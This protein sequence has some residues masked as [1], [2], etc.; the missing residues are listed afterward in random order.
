MRRRTRVLVDGAAGA[1]TSADAI[2]GSSFP[3]VAGSGRGGIGLPS[4]AEPVGGGVSAKNRRD[5]PTA[6]PVRAMVPDTP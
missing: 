4:V 1:H 3:T 5:G 6:T 2:R